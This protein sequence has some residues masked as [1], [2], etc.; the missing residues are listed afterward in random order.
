M[1]FKLRKRIL[2]LKVSP[3]TRKRFTGG[4][5]LAFFGFLVV[6]GFYFLDYKIRPALK[7]LAEAKARQVTTEAINEAINFKI[8]PDL[9]YENMIDVSFDK[10][11]KVALMRPNSG[12]INRLAIK[13][14]LA[15]QKKIKHLAPQTV[16]LPLGQMFGLKILANIGPNL[17]VRLQSIGIVE[18]VI[19]D[20]FD[21]AGINQ[22]RHQIKINIKTVIKI[23]VPL[24]YQQV[25]INTSVLLTEAIV[26]GQVPHIYV[27]GGG[28]IVPGD[29]QK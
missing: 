17:P 9:K 1:R 19:S 21:V 13:A 3:F 23:I 6:A 5:L 8:A 4:L 7:Y 18:S 16:R 25:R 14:T 26:M 12:E 28:L 24:V 10:D 22:I 15:V 2:K 11:G 20:N 29:S 27:N